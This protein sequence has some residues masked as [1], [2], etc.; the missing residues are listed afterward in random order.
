M[1]LDLSVL[2]ESPHPG[3][4]TALVENVRVHGILQPIVVRC[5]ENGRLRIRFGARRFRA[6]VQRLTHFRKRPRADSMMPCSRP[7]AI[8]LS[9]E[10][11]P[12]RE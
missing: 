7:P 2:D 10:P 6:A 5:R 12:R 3:P 9:P 8:E 11:T 4:S 1:A